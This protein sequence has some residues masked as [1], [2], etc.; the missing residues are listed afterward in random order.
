MFLDKKGQIFEKEQMKMFMYAIIV[1]FVALIISVVFVQG[2][3][4]EVKVENL[5]EHTIAYRLFSSSD[6][7][8]DCSGIIDLNRFYNE[9]LEMCLNLPA[10]TKAGVEMILYDFEGT[11]VAITEINPSMVAQKVTCGMKTARVDC[12][13]TKKY[14]LYDDGELKQGVLDLVV[15]ANV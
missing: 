5:V 11:E 13:E 4:R 6:C 10:N 1:I 14:V 3:N 15:I 9:N 7:F 12:Y 2:V 8:S